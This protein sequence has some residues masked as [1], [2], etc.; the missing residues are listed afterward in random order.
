MRK[1]EVIEPRESQQI[2][3][4]TLFMVADN[5]MQTTLARMHS[6]YRGLR[7]WRVLHWYKNHTRE[8]L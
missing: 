4:D 1:R 7:A 3:V 6:F 8:I 2:E 5:N